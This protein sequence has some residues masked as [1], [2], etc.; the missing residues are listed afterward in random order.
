[1][2]QERPVKEF[3]AGAIS[4]AIWTTTTIVDG[5]SVEQHSIRVQKRYRDAR[6]GEW[7]TTGYLQP[8]DLPKLV[9]VASKAF[10]HMTLREVEESSSS[11]TTPEASGRT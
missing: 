7:K 1:M 2:P 11:A 10:E 5:R 8:Q 4:A 9:L 3:R 6:S